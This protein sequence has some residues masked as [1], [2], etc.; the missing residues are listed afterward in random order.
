MYLLAKIDGVANV[1]R[2]AS[3]GLQC[4]AP[5]VK[6]DRE[7]IQD[8]IGR[9]IIVRFIGAVPMQRIGPNF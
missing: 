8:H 7:S 3:V 2:N 5:T 4:S 1:N 9:P 6:R